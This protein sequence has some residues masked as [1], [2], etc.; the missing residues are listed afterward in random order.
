[1]PSL[2]TELLKGRLYYFDSYGYKPPNQV[3]ILIDRLIEQGKKNNI[4]MEFKQNTNRH[5]YKESECGMYS[6]KFIE[7]MLEGCP[8]DTFCK[9][10]LTDDYIHSFRNKYFINV[11]N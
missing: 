8:F 10:K 11:D 3:Q 7:Q 6:I 4:E 2:A 1:M 5:Q 9:S